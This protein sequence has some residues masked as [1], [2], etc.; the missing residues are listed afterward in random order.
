MLLTF[1]QD[2]VISETTFLKNAVGVLG[3]QDKGYVMIR[4]GSI[5]W[6]STNLEA[7]D[8]A[9]KVEIIIYKNGEEFGFR[10]TFQITETNTYEDYD[11]ISND[12]LIFEKGD[13]ISTKVVI[14]GNIQIRDITTLLEI[15][16]K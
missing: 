4:D 10:N 13:L 5:T 6:L 14:S 15:E 9:G 3:S 8:G 11:S 12:V 16:T 7:I 2:E 1:G